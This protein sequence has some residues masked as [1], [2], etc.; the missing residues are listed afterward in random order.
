MENNFK[1]LIRV[2]DFLPMFIEETY[3]EKIVYDMVYNIP[4]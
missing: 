4:N 1:L 3:I 2:M